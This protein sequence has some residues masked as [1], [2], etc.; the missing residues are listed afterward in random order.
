MA[1]S[2]DDEEFRIGDLFGDDPGVPG[3]FKGIF[4]AADHQAG[5]GDLLQMFGDVQV[6]KVR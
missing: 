1:A 5:E 2:G 3:G 6:R 4:G